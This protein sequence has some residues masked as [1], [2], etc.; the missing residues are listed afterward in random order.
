[1]VV[2]P[3]FDEPIV[4]PSPP[5]GEA[6]VYAPARAVCLPCAP[7]LTWDQQVVW[8]P[9]ACVGPGSMEPTNQNGRKYNEYP[10]CGN[11]ASGCYHDA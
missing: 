1:M 9:A 5:A 2:T 6:A 11:D 10:M 3:L 4:N 7:N 8:S